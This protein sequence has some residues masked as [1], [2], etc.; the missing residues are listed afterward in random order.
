[1]FSGFSSKAWYTQWMVMH[2]QLA[3]FVHASEA[4]ASSPAWSM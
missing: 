3:T 2:K 4:Y 1:M